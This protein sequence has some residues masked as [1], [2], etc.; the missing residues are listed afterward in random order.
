MVVHDKPI[1]FYVNKLKNNEYFSI[2]MYGDGEWIAIFKE[3]IGK[4]NAEGTIY[5]KEL[6][7]ALEQSMYFQSEN[8]YFSTPAGLKNA[9]HTGI[10]EKKLDNWLSARNLNIEF[11]EKDSWNDWAREAKL[12]HFIQQLRQMNVCI[13]SNKALRGLNFLGYDHFIEIS[14]PNCFIDG[15]LENAYNEAIKYG[16]SGV[17]LIAAGLPAALLV[18]RL[19]NQIPNSWFLDLGSTWDGFVKIGAQ[20]G[21][22][23]ELYKD[24]ERWLRWFDKNLY[25]EN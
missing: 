2:G 24:K 15:S 14:Y 4:T 22:R 12:Y 25:G 21:W 5:T 8:F 17:Y 10:G 13:I 3:R 1:E 23:Q 6:C 16:K 9:Q 18:Q 11:L 7:D 19:H 20:R